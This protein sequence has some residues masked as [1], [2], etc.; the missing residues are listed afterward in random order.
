[1]RRNFKHLLNPERNR[2]DA[3]V[4]SAK[5]KGRTNVTRLDSKP[6][7]F[8]LRIWEKLDKYWKSE[9]FEKRSAAGKKARGNVEVTARTGANPCTQKWEV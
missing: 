9:V 4:K 1:M 8:S 7:Y 5:D 2:A 6:H 3:K